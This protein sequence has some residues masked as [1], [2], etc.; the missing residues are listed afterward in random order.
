MAPP[1]RLPAFIS[2]G[3]GPLGTGRREACS[4]ALTW[5]CV[6]VYVVSGV[7]AGL[8]AAGE[9]A[10][11]T[12]GVASLELVERLL[13]TAH[14]RLPR[15]GLEPAGQRGRGA[16]PLPAQGRGGQVRHPG[17]PPG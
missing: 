5:G 12:L 3:V 14:Q 16:Q 6:P 4:V 9:P 10:R 17:G 2:R 7:A 1:I 15:G 13:P 8:G 11:E